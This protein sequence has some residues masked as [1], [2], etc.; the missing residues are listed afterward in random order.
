MLWLMSTTRDALVGDAA[1]QLEHLAVWR[2]PRA[3]VGSS[4]NTSWF[5]HMIERQIATLWRWPPDS[6][7]QAPSS[8]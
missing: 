4:M 5:A 1:D 7:R 3:A 6:A 2:T 8:P